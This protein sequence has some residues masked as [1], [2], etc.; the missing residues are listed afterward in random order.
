MGGHA[1]RRRCRARPASQSPTGCS[2]GAF[3]TKSS[4]IPDPTRPRGQRAPPGPVSPRAHAAWPALALAVGGRGRSSALR[5]AAAPPYAAPSTRQAGHL[6]WGRFTPAFFITVAVLRWASGVSRAVR[7][8]R[9]DHLHVRSRPTGLPAHDAPPDDLRP[10]SRRS[11]SVRCR[12]T[13]GDPARGRRPARLGEVARTAWP[14]DP[15]VDPP[16][17][18]PPRDRRHVGDPRR[19]APRLKAGSCCSGPA[20]RCSSSCTAPPTSRSRRSSS[21]P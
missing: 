21:R 20:S 14:R 19:V 8:P 12:S 13:Q 15:P 3:A 5:R 7:E 17:R 10:T 1:R 16:A 2:W 9:P 11:C 6:T 4:V 18:S